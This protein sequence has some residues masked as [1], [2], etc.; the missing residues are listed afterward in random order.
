[1][2]A[3]V[4]RY[5]LIAEI[6]DGMSLILMT[7]KSKII[8]LLCL[9][10]CYR[11]KSYEERWKN[12]TELLYTT[13]TVCDEEPEPAKKKLRSSSEFRPSATRPGAQATRCP[14]LL[15]VKCIFCKRERKDFLDKATG[16]RK[17]EPLQR[18]ELTVSEELLAAAELKQDEDL[19]LQI[20]G[21][22]LVAAELRY[23]N[24]CKV[25]YTNIVRSLKKT[26]TDNESSYDKMTRQHAA[27]AA[28]KR[29]IVQDRIVQGCEIFRMTKASR[30]VQRLFEVTWDR[31]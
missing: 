30:T 2:H 28:F 23:H 15:P 21:V 31:F 24:R 25:A 16:K 13:P 20:R 19:L 26:A 9:V 1:M 3:C 5:T 8:A 10:L 6:E 7:E 11:L 18:C 27:Y 29:E 12:Y 14:S 4:L 22:D 17:V